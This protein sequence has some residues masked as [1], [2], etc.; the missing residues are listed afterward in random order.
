MGWK[1]VLSLDLLKLV[2]PMW[3]MLIGAPCG[4]HCAGW[5]GITVPARIVMTQGKSR[6][7]PGFV[8]ACTPTSS[9]PKI[10]QYRVVTVQS[11]R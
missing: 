8:P 9:L 2:A 10:C 3:Y 5:P 7:F 6:L 11:T 1:L 4:T